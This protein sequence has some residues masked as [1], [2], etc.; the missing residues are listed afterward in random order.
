MASFSSLVRSSA[1][2]HT[3]VFQLR[4]A[5][6]QRGQLNLRVFI[7]AFGFLRRAVRIRAFA[8]IKVRQRQFGVD[9]VVSSAGFTFPAT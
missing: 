6:F 7:A 4:Q 1:R 3:G 5:F 8:G 2:T 9:N